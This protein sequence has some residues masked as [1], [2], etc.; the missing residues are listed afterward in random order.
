MFYQC[1]RQES[2]QRIKVGRCQRGKEESKAYPSHADT[3]H[4]IG[5]GQGNGGQGDEFKNR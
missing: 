2:A 4:D 5:L 1:I 3:I